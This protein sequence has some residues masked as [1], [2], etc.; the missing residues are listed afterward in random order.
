FN[1]GFA[2][3]SYQIEG[4]VQEEGRGPS[5]WDT[6]CYREPTRTKG[7]N[8]DVACDHYHRWEEDLDILQSYGAKSCRF[9]FSWSRIIPLGGRN[10]PLNEAGI[11]FYNK[12]IDGLLARGIE[13]WITLY[14]WGVTKD[15]Q[16]RKG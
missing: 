14:R 5:I 1:W 13:P 6:F 11:S 15:S 8:G 16:E 2:T 9:S 4:A 10:D 3:A 12:L 7:A